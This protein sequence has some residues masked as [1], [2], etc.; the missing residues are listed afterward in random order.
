MRAA[1]ASIED[2]ETVLARYEGEDLEDVL[3]LILRLRGPVPKVRRNLRDDLADGHLS[4]QAEIWASFIVCLRQSGRASEAAALE[5]IFVTEG[6][7][8][9]L[10]VGPRIGM[11]ENELNE[12]FTTWTKAT[13]LKGQASAV[14]ELSTTLFEGRRAELARN[15]RKVD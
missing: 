15:Q 8:K 6:P 11:D 7:S 9:I 10:S 4:R 5:H 3:V 14:D 13:D 1:V 2:A 12:I